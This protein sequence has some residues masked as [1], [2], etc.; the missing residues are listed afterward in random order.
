ME[1]GE[2]NNLVAVSALN[3]P[4]AGEPG[5]KDRRPDP[6]KCFGRMSMGLML[7]KSE[8]S[9]SLHATTRSTAA[10]GYVSRRI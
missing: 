7:S 6:G 5:P 9:A 1:A 2:E 8:L 10:Y 3:A 4:S